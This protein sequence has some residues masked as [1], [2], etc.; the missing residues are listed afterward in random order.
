MRTHGVFYTDVMGDG[1]MRA[2][3]LLSCGALAFS[4]QTPPRPEQQAYQQQ[5]REVGAKRDTLR[6]QAKQAFDAEMSRQRAGDCPTANTTY[7]S[8]LCFGREVGITDRNLKTYGTAIRDLLGL[9]NPASNGL[10]ATPAPAVAEFD[11]LEQLWQSYSG[12]ASTAAFH[13]FSGG[14]GGPG[15]EMRCHLLLAR[16]H[17]LELDTIYGMLLEF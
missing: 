1:F 14:T 16:S 15:F 5:M 8:N 9:Q 7:D 11:H 17:L 2:I 13:Q 3:A 10:S 4:Q 12:V 6:A